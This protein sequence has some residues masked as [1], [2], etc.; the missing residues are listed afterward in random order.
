M[1]LEWAGACAARGGGL[2]LPPAV[3]SALTSA[4]KSS[5]VILQNDLLIWTIRMCSSFP[6]AR[7]LLRWLLD[8]WHSWSS[9]RQ[10][11]GQS[12]V[13]SGGWTEV[14]PSTHSKM[15]CTL[16]HEP[17][18]PAELPGNI[19]SMSCFDILEGNCNQEHDQG[20]LW[21]SFQQLIGE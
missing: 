6:S 5:H 21:Y 3:N 7:T 17:H 16:A 12:S 1:S 14:V 4:L 15:W 18:D 11:R 9:D 2:K 13:S 8:G 19:P 10:N 20:G